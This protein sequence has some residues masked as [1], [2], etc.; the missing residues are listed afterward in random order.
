MTAHDNFYLPVNGGQVSVPFMS[1]ASKQHIVSRPGYK[2]LMLPYAG[3]GQNGASFSMYIYL[4]DEIDGLPSMLARLSS[5]PGRLLENSWTTT[6]EVPVGKFRVPKF[7]MS[8]KTTAS[9]MLRKMGLSL[10]F[11]ALRADFGEMTV[12]PP[13]EPIYA[14]EVFHECFVEV[15]EEGTEAAAATAVAMH[16]GCAAAPPPEDFVADHPFM[17]VIKEEFSGVVVFAGQVINP[18]V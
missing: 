12:G 14:P 5:D 3:G 18:S 1:S 9:A 10:P 13:P 16:F 8:C 15:N 7:T 17:F 6:A 2:V 11:D 4:P